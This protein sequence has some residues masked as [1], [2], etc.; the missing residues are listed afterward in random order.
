MTSH[1]NS[2][3]FTTPSEHKLSARQN[4]HFQ[5]DLGPLQ[6]RQTISTIVPDQTKLQDR[7]TRKKMAPIIYGTVFGL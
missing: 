6:H 5:K 4:N 1:N 3:K 2:E 7:G